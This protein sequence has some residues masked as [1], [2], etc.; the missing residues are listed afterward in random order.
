M[1]IPGDMDRGRPER[2]SV[3]VWRRVS[4]DL[5]ELCATAAAARPLPPRQPARGIA[6][7]ECT[8]EV[9][10]PP[11][12]SEP[13]HDR[14]ERR[15]DVGDAPGVEVSA[16]SRLNVTPHRGSEA[17][18]L[19]EAGVPG[20][21]RKPSPKVKLLRDMQTRLDPSPAAP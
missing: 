20:H 3:L 17:E 6:A 2:T 11:P 13:I 21:A 7:G 12:R 15:G 10:A 8:K 1:Q 19:T 4:R 5:R 9:R 14:L 18:E 16:W